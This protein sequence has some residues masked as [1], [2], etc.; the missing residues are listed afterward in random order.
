MAIDL[1]RQ[2]QIQGHKNDGPVNGMEADNILPHQMD[3][4]RPIFFHELGLII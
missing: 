4:R 2:G 3:I 1:V